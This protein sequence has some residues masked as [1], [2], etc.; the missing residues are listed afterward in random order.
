MKSITIQFLAQRIEANIQLNH[1][2]VKGKCWW[3][4]TTGFIIPL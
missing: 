2:T 3:A 1:S 4:A